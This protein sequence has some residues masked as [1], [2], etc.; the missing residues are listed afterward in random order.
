[1][2]LKLKDKDVFMQDIEYWKIDYFEYVKGKLR[3]KLDGYKNRKSSIEGAE[4][5]DKEIITIAYDKT[6][7]SFKQLYK[8]VK[9]I[10]KFTTAED[11]IE[12]K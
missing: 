7:V 3:I 2:G 1:M 4:P 9:K 12:E 10:T 11:V 5:S 8:A 6:S